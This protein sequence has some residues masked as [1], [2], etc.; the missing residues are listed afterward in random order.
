MPK[1]NTSRRAR[2]RFSYLF[3]EEAAEQSR[4]YDRREP[5]RLPENAEA[6]PASKA[7]P[8]KRGKA[9]GSAKG[10][11]KSTV[12][13]IHR[14]QRRRYQKPPMPEQKEEPIVRYLEEN[15]GEAEAFCHKPLDPQNISAKAQ[16]K[17]V[18]GGNT[19]EV[20]L[21]RSKTKWKR[22]RR[23]IISLSRV[24]RYIR[25][26]QRGGKTTRRECAGGTKGRAVRAK[27]KAGTEKRGSGRE[28]VKSGKASPGMAARLIREPSRAKEVL[29]GK[30][31]KIFVCVSN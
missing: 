1:R 4:R 21:K 10:L 26:R 23:F 19:V 8:Q 17:P 18:Q 30:D 9:G 25:M 5:R 22:S 24:R 27:R 7:D 16:A 2:H 20:V 12:E 14:R 11:M 3:E 31:G 29:V 28:A 6:P 15:P 13:D